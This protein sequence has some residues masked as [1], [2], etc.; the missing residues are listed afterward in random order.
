LEG[1]K[2]PSSRDQ[3]PKRFPNP[4]FSFFVVASVLSHR[5][6]YPSKI[7]TL[8]P[9]RKR[10][11]TRQELVAGGLQKKITEKRCCFQARGIQ[12]SH[13]WKRKLPRPYMPEPSG[14]TGNF[15]GRGAERSMDRGQSPHKSLPARALPVDPLPSFRDNSCFYATECLE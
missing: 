12:L 8:L 14:D 2:L 15:R 6:Q 3:S 11:E 9:D 7:Q 4:T 1:R 10:H 5:K 13:V